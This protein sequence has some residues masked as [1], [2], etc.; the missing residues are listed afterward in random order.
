MMMIKERIKLQKW[1][2]IILLMVIFMNYLITTSFGAINVTYDHRALVIDGKCRV[3]ASGS[4]HYPRST[5]EMWGDL[6]QKSKD[7]GLDIIETY[8][9]WDLHE[10]VRGQYDFNGRKDL[11]KFVKLVGEAGLYVHLRIGPYVCAE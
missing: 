4:I 11:V 5:P 7:G 8:V 2:I 3:L 10:P 9:F 6:I 1:L